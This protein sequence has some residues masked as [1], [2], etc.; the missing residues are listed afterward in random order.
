M[1]KMVQLSGEA[2][3]DEDGIDWISRSGSDEKVCL[4]GDGAESIEQLSIG[5]PVDWVGRLS[6]EEFGMESTARFCID[7]R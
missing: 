2:V 6:M 4:L 7:V 5:E 1:G 3:T